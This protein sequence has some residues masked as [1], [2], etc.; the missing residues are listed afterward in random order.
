MRSAFLDSAFDDCAVNSLA[1]SNGGRNWLGTTK[2]ECH[3]PRT[4]S[5][6]Y[7]ASSN[8]LRIRTS[9]AVGTAALPGH[10]TDRFSSGTGSTARGQFGVLCT[11]GGQEGSLGAI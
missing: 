3:C 1:P 4:I 11:G 7:G 6:A 10:L 9:R 2:P 5:S 8:G